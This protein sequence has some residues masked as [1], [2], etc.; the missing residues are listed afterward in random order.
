MKTI[1]R[2]IK[3]NYITQLFGENKNDFYAELK[4]KGHNGIDFLA[5]EKEPIYWDIESEGKVIWCGTDDKGGIGVEIV[6]QENDDYYKSRFWHLKSFCIHKGKYL[7]FGDLIGYADNTGLSTGTHLHRDIKKCEQDGTTINSNNG[8]KGCIDY[9]SSFKNIFV[10]DIIRLE[11]LP[12]G[13]CFDSDLECGDVSPK[14]AI[15]KIILQNELAFCPNWSI[16]NLFGSQTKDAVQRF[17]L[18]YKSEIDKAAGTC[19]HCTGKI[20]KGTRAVLNRI[21][22]EYLE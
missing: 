17:Q 3:S 13:Y 14:V 1:Y 2:A 15:L 16:T 7:K 20:G 8:Y 19:T 11:A 4:M 18:K 9:F 12:V 6:S 21:L 22:K 10:N 5:I